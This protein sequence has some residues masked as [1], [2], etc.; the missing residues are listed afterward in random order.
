M[1]NPE[2][3]KDKIAG[4]ATYVS[5]FIA[6]AVVMIAIISFNG[7][8][9]VGA[10]NHF[11]QLPV[12][13]RLIDPTYLPAD[14]SIELRLYHHRVFSYL[15]AGLTLLIGEDN[16]LITL[17]IAGMGLLAFSLWWLCRIA[18]LSLPGYLAAGIALATNFLWVGRG[19]ELNHFAGDAAIMPP[20]FAH[21]FV[22]LAL[23]AA[24]REKFYQAAIFA[25]LA[26]LFHL[27]IGLISAAA[28]APIYLW[29]RARLGLRGLVASAALFLIAAAAG[30]IDLI[31]LL[32]SGVAGGSSEPYTRQF[33]IDFRH[34][35]H[36]ELLSVIAAISIIIYTVIQVL[37]VRRDSGTGKYDRAAKI[38]AAV[39]VALVIYALLHFADYYLIRDDRL[40]TIQFIRLSPLISVTGFVSALIWLRSR[41][42]ATRFMLASVVIV[43]LA[44]LW[45]AWQV[46]YYEREF[47][48]G[49]ARYADKTSTW[50]RVCQ[51][52]G[53]N[54][55]K[56]G[57]YITPPGNN[58][59]TSLS[60]RSTIADFKNN[61]DGGRG[62]V[63]WFDRLK[64]LSGGSLPE[65]RGF[66]NRDLLNQAYDGLS[67]EQLKAISDK[68][69]AEYAVVSSKKKFP[70]ETVYRNQRYQVVRISG[71][72]R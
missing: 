1:F 68:Y 8:I 3:E 9:S 21:A 45:G 37:A 23:A 24:I 71:E 28:L 39:S 50:V 67:A 16:A 57:V 44:L 65:G 26:A 18:G 11:G 36:F 66:D 5:A 15:I 61:P 51:W 62:M 69:K 32:R 53:S 49:I 20:T 7:G 58:G 48:P 31:Q 10:S 47:V 33:Y 35:H 56:E 64:D 34:P 4:A 60:N 70:F 43:I 25:G 2:R 30:L 29:N 41:I 40:A 63:E 52:V 59:F 27:Q 38:M 46:R 6:I 54:G 72:A 13:R 12:V 14:F 55:P 19:L 42:S 17:G 22:L